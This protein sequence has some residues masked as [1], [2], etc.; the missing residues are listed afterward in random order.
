M[1][2]GNDPAKV[3]NMLKQNQRA[4]SETRKEVLK[5]YADMLIY[6]LGPAKLVP[7]MCHHKLTTAIV[8]S[9][10]LSNF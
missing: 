2:T 6:A 8:T 3:L 1:L 9:L 5:I 7:T 4:A 10:T